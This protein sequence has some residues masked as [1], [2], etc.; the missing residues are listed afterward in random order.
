MGGRKAKASAKKPKSRAAHAKKPKPKPSKAKKA[1]RRASPKP[2]KTAKRQAKPVKKAARMKARAAKP[3]QAKKPAR[4]MAAKSKIQAQPRLQK[5]RKNAQ[6]EIIEESFAPIEKK[7]TGLEVEIVPAILAHARHEFEYKMYSVLPHAKRIQIDIMDGKFV[8]NTTVGENEKVP[9]KDSLT[10]EY[11]LMVQNPID[12]IK[13]IDN[14]DAI[15]I[16]H[17]EAQEGPAEVVRF[18]KSEG[19]RVGLAINPATRI[20]ELDRFIEDIEMVLFMTVVPGFSGQ[21]YMKQVEGKI[22]EFKKKYPKV[23]VEVDGGISEENV[24]G[25]RQA[26]ANLFAAA[27]SI[28][29]SGEVKAA[30]EG[31]YAKASHKG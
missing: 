15:Y 27:S 18:C 25:A 23:P 22:A 16:A 2:K 6:Q 21:K 7:I 26:G 8:P 30:M 13:L 31:L 24:E 29:S 17:V 4:Q 5:R 1:A 10:V 28:F 9:L 20:E 11:H 12:Y 14:P 19:Y 3:K